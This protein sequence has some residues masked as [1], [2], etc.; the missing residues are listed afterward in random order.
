MKKPRCNSVQACDSL[1]PD[2]NN[3][4]HCIQ[5]WSLNLLT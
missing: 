3:L 2:P 1:D 4:I 5:E